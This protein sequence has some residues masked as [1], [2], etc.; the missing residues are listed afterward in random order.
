MEGFK[1]ERPS[2]LMVKVEDA[3]VIEGELV[4]E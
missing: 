1:I 3:L 4:F 2:L